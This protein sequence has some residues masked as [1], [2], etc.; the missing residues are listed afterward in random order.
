MTL[1]DS[2][3]ADPMK[4]LREILDDTNP[5]DIWRPIHDAEGRLVAQAGGKKDDLPA[6]DM[7]FL[8]FRGKS[9]LDL[10][11]NFGYFSFLARRRGAERVLGVEINDRLVEACNLQKKLHGLEGVEFIAANFNSL[12]LDRPFD[13]VLFLDILGSHK[14]LDGRLPSALDT[15]VRFA[16]KEMVATVQPV[17]H[18]PGSLGIEAA[19]LGSRYPA[20]FVRDNCFYL[21]EYVRDYFRDDWEMDMHPAE[22]EADDQTRRMLHFKKMNEVHSSDAK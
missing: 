20:A 6:A 10:G 13:I 3:A 15:M 16:G 11:C 9:V 2:I 14:I 22:H 21:G 1:S 8:D 4:R 19:D 7:A 18:L 17:Y 5:N 12:E